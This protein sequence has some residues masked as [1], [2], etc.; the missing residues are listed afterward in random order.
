[1]KQISPQHQRLLHHPFTE[2]LFELS[3][4]ELPPFMKAPNVPLPVEEL[5]RR[6]VGYRDILKKARRHLAMKYHPDHADDDIKM[7]EIND[8]Y[9]FLMDTIHE[10]NI[11]MTPPR[12]RV[13]VQVYNSSFGGST[14]TSNTYTTTQYM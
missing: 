9:D 3:P 14:A 6:I 2:K 10:K 13:Y 4:G 7:K 5:K 11:R 8:A 1:M 12:R